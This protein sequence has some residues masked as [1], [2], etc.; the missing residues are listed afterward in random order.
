MNKN[1]KNVALWFGLATIFCLGI[2]VFM[3]AEKASQFASAYIIEE[4]LSI[5]NL[6]VF[7][8]VFAMFRVEPRT[9]EI[10][11][12]W[13]IIG[14]AFLRG[15]F[16]LLGSVLIT[17]FHPLLYILG[18]FLLYSAIKMIKSGDE[19]EVPEKALELARRFKLNDFMTCLLV[20]EFSDLVFALD[21]IPSTFAI[22]Q[23][24]FIVFTANMFAIM[25]LR[26][27]YF[28]LLEWL[29]KFENLKYGISI[30][31]VMIGFKI[32][33]SGVFEIP[34]WISLVLTFGI[35]GVSILSSVKGDSIEN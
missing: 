4:S 35:L 2:L 27:L 1:L 22:T 26:S 25:G 33:I 10:M 8:L 32:L 29:D 20:I 24:P 5:D 19:P 11:L 31:L 3:G 13:G 17:L 15:T 16:I 34:T 30:V 12:R 6:F 18:A 9:Q 23:D 7:S 14:A 21:S 28:I